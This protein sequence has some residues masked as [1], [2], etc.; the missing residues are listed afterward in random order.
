MKKQ[1]F[2]AAAATVLGLS[3]TTGIA[4]AQSVSNTGADSSNTVRSKTVNVNHVWNHTHLAADNDNMQA[5]ATGAASSSFNTTGGGAMSGDAS[6]ATALNVSATIDNSGSSGGSGGSMPA[7]STTGSIDTTGYNSTNTVSSKVVNV[8]RV[9]NDT[10]VWV[11]NDNTQTASSGSASVS[12]NTTGGSATSGDASNSSSSS[13]TFNI[14][15]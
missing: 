7:A 12:Y 6:N 15:N 14:T 13:F 1:L 5:A 3:L 9:S 10:S 2:R 4:A 8:N 11:S